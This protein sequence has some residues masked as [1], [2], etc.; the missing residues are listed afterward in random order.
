[1]ASDLGRPAGYWNSATVVRP[2]GTDGWAHVLDEIDRFFA[3]PERPRSLELF[4]PFPTPDLRQRGWELGGHPPAMWLPAGPPRSPAHARVEVRAVRDE[5]A[6][7]EWAVSAASWFPIPGAGADLVTLALLG[8]S[9]IDLFV[10]RVD[11][12]PVS[13]SSSVLAHGTNAIPLV[14]TDPNAR[15]RGFG[16]A[17]TWAAA[18]SRAGRPTVLLASDDGQPVYRRMGFVPLSRWTLWTR[19]AEG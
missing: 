18:R 8:H 16:S 3:E 17:A 5:G 2:L 1:M 13:I 6:L 12:E 7:R 11:D 4:S 19:P 15:G 9:D 14:A 10:G